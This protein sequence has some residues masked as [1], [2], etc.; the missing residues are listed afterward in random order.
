MARTKKVLPE[1]V[2]VREGYASRLR[3][4]ALWEAER[5]TNRGHRHM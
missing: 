4:G 1:G 2:K 3:R 5:L